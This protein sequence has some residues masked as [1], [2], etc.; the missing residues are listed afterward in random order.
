MRRPLVSVVVLMGLLASRP[1][2]V[3]AQRLPSEPFVFGDGRVVV[4]GDVSLTAS[5]SHAAKSAAC[6][7]DTGFF[8][9]SDYDESLLRMVRAGLSTAV[10]LTDRLSA[11]ADFR[12]ENA[13]APRPYGLYVR[14][15]P[16]EARDFDLQAG[17]IPTAFGAFPRRAYSTDNLLISYPL[18][19]QYLTSLRP[20][21]VPATADDLIRMRGRGWL[22]SFPIGEQAP[23]AGL[24]LVNAL[25]WDTGVQIHA[26]SSWLEGAAAMTTGSLSNPLVLDD[27]RGRNLSG[28]L[29]V[30]PA[31]GLNI[32]I[33]AARAPYATS[34]A[35][36][37]AH[38]TDA[39]FTQTAFGIDAE[40]SR[41]HYLVRVES[42]MSRYNLPTITSRL[43]AT[44]TMLEGRYKIT[45]RLHAAAR[46]DHLAFSRIRGSTLF[47]TWE[48][49]VTRWEVG[50][51]YSLQRNTQVRLSFQRNT[52]EGG[53]VQRLSAA[54]AQLLYWF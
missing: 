42:V 17:R 45:P 54:A 29:M 8:N 4:S 36:S 2:R 21:A 18:A 11:L 46:F 27:N 25:R 44:G 12:T 20:D 41:D 19:Y 33:S 6:T 22:S 38:A 23:A 40:Y 26:G 15:K 32:G 9:Y 31:T 24:P 28:R 50:T 39:R 3:E 34:D 48:A 52:R 30:K 1:A 43:R 14:F 13:H 53:R 5:C 7:S 49:P 47:T 16:F 37:A 10:R 35:A 51:G